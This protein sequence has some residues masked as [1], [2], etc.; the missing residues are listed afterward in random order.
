MKINTIR[1]FHNFLNELGLESGYAKDFL[2]IIFKYKDKRFYILDLEKRKVVQT[3]QTFSLVSE[4]ISHVD[5]TVLYELYIETYSMETYSN[6]KTDTAVL[7]FK[8]LEDLK[9]VESFIKDNFKFLNKEE[10][11][12]ERSK[13]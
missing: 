4:W 6:N 8:S 5:E 3:S 9:K 12:N 1:E 7:T 10:R 2:Y 13:N 11:K